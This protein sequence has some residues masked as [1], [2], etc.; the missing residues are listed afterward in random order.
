MGVSM[1]G[2]AERGFTLIELVGVVALIGIVGGA[3]IPTF[4]NNA[5]L[6]QTAEA[7]TNVKKV[8]L[9]QVECESA[10]ERFCTARELLE[11]GYVDA[12]TAAAFGIDPL[13]SPESDSAAGGRDRGYMFVL[14]LSPDRLHFVVTADPA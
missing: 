2:H 13:L 5:R 11:G 7:T 8:Y 12:R 6:A 9:A 4:M 14:E 10:S 1:P 3:A